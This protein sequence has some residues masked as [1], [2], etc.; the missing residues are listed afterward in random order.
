MMVDSLLEN[1]TRQPEGSTL[2]LGR[3]RVFHAG[4]AVMNAV[5]VTDRI[6]G[7]DSLVEPS[8]DVEKPGDLTFRRSCRRDSAQ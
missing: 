7:T 6:V 4:C 3:T 5:G 8:H 2:G 1:Q